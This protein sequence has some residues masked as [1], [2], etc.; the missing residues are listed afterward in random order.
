MG[1]ETAQGCGTKSAGLETA[2]GG[3]TKAPEGETAQGGGPGGEG[4]RGGGGKA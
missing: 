1:G 3:G 2:Q 4:T